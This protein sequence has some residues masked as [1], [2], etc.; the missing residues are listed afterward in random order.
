M[1]NSTSTPNPPFSNNAPPISQPVLGDGGVFTLPWYKYLQSR[2]SGSVTPAQ[3]A[4]VE[5]VAER[6]ET[7]AQT[8]TTDA[9]AAEATAQEAL[10]AAGGISLT[11]LLT[12]SGL[13][14]TDGV[15]LIQTGTGLTGGPITSTGTIS[16][17]TIANNDLLANISG[18]VAAPVPNTLTAIIDSALGN[19]QG[20]ILYRDASA[21]KVLAPG[22]SGWFLETLGAG[23][24]PQWA[25]VSGGSG[26]VT[27]VS[28]SAPLGGGTVTTSGTLGTTS[29]TAHGVLLGEGTSAIVAT[30]AGGAN[31]FLAGVAAADPTFRAPVLASADFANQGT[32]T[33]LLHGNAAGNPTFGSVV[34]GDIAASAVTLAKIQN[35]ASNSI[36]LGSG[37]TGSGSPYVELSLGT[38]LSMSGTTLNATGGGGSGTVTSITVASPSSSIAISG[39]NPITTSGT[40]DVDIASS[41]A[42]PGSPT[43]TTQ[44][45]A[46]N[47]T[48]VATTAYVTT[49]VTN[50]LAGVNPAVAVQAATTAA[51]DTSSF[52]YNNGVGGIGATL[53]GTVNTAV[54]IDGYTFAALGQRLL[55]K[56][57]TQSPSG[58]FNG[59]YYVTQVQTSLLAPILTRALDYDQP[60]DINN[61]GAIPV[62]NGTVNADT[63]WLLTSTVNT[64]GTDPLTYAQFSV[65]PANVLQTGGSNPTNHGVLL[66]KG[67]NVAGST[68][69]GTAGQVLTSNGASA[70]P[71]FQPASSG[72]SGANPTA[73]AGPNAVNGSATT[74]M[75][76][77]GA[78]A[79]QLGSAS[80]AGIVETDNKTTVA[81]ASGL[82]SAAIP[83]PITG[84]FSRA[85]ATRGNVITPGVSVTISN[86]TV[87]MDTVANA[88]YQVGVAAFNTSTHKTTSANTLSTTWSPGATPLTAA[89]HVFNISGGFAFVAGTSYIVFLS[90]TDSTAGATLASYYITV[91]GT[92]GL[93][94]PSL[95][96]F[97]ASAT[98]WWDATTVPPSTGDTWTN[99]TGVY[100]IV[101]VN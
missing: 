29:F 67:T 16:L 53:T 98:T 73:T 70:D 37:A 18:G 63:S 74:F 68:A 58:A 60:S 96:A 92:S 54:T 88:T 62:V 66:G 87:L 20:D 36:L 33:T 95:Q 4:A 78:P 57:D 9:Q 39:T 43:T 38:N 32:T 35:A 24:N 44:S 77:D 59:V 30:A 10:D 42:L 1:A 64:V 56:N 46:D 85:A 72:A 97:T 48:K 19:T 100:F 90:R 14:G 52:T 91:T 101:P 65:A 93:Y 31:T 11:G 45:A 34:T 86:F 23:A 27:S 49:A 47:S 75:R 17:S 80:Q 8:A 55:V 51:G 3:L 13:D 61:T 26:T 79:I 99:E 40:V 84:V 89:Q 21:W 69:A 2:N 94:W 22:T 81:N 76:S 83:L 5:A 6:A 15:Y 71:T 50:A 41:A 82:I 12:I 25:A 7:D 28:L